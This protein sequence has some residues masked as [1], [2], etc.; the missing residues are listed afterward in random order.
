MV[1]AL[2][3]LFLFYKIDRSYPLKGPSKWPS[4]QQVFPSSTSTVNHRQCSCGEQVCPI[5]TM[6]D[7]LL[8]VVAHQVID[9]KQ[10]P[11]SRQCSR[12]LLH[13]NLSLLIMFTSF[14]HLR[15]TN[16]VVIAKRKATNCVAKCEALYYRSS[17]RENIF[18]QLS[19]IAISQ[20]E[21]DPS[22]QPYRDKNR[23]WSSIVEIGYC[24]Q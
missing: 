11:R 21:N 24:F 8:R 22:Q 20:Y 6:P 14:C 3:R 1:V 4:H 9:Q 19:T 7:A 2:F 16:K 12:Q 13:K 23:K 10:C 15:P 18:M 17:R 5:L